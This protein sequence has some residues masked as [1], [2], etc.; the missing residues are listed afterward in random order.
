M[1]RARLFLGFL[2]VLAILA[3][4]GLYATWLISS[5]VGETEGV[6]FRSYRSA[7]AAQAMKEAIWRMDR[8]VLFSLDGQIGTGRLLFDANVQ[9]FERSLAVQRENAAGAEEERLL[10]EM[11][12]SFG[13]YRAA[14]ERILGQTNESDQRLVY[15]G[16]FAPRQVILSGLAGEIQRVNDAAMAQAEEKILGARRQSL[17]F[18][19]GALAMALV[20]A[21]Y[22]AYQS[23][24][25]ILHPIQSLT[26]SATEVGR[27]NLDQNVPVVSRDELGQLADAFNRMAAQLRAARERLSERIMRLHRSREAALD[28]F[29]DPIFVLDSDGRI[30]LTNEAADELAARLGPESR[31][32]EALEPRIRRALDAGESFLPT[33][34]KDALAV[35]R[36]GD[37]RFYLPRVLAVRSPAGATIG[38]AVMLLDLTRFRLLDDVKNDLVAT[39]SH[40]LK[41]PLTSVLMVLHLL[42]ERTLGPLTRKQAEMVVTACRDAERLQRIMTDLLDLARLEGESADLRLESVTAEELVGQ[43]LRE[44]REMV[45]GKGLNLEAE[46]EP[47]LPPVEVDVQRISH[48]F[49]NFISNAVKHSPPGGTILL[50]VRRTPEGAI[51]FAVKDQGPGIAPEFQARVFEKFFRVPDQQKSGAGLGLSIA[52][53]IVAAHGGHIGVESEPGSGT[54]FFAELQCAEQAATLPHPVP[55]TA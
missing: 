34:F 37:E 36:E 6:F 9:G 42:A 49:A 10:R 50:R 44:Q 55:E 15:G 4:V 18:M 5:V 27:G 25:M 19:G 47:G 54:E 20:L 21:M 52:R 11:L 41:T 48:V 23:G 1:L 8:G 31:M 38:V 12:V 46:V 32:P 51:R 39:V 2:P 17:W 35:S 14:G 24:R 30:E 13:A 22:A 45:S 33:S 43:A 26:R 7:A 53:E 28:T 29:P 3:A 40:E 16:Q